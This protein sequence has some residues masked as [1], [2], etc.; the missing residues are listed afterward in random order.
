M[1]PKNI[2]TAVLLIFV[3]ASFGYLV[4]TETTSSERANDGQSPSAVTI[5]VGD[6]SL[7]TSSLADQSRDAPSHWIITYYFHNTQRCKTCL[8]IERLAEEALREEF[9]VEFKS[10]AIEWR[11]LNMEESPNTH[12]VDDYQ[13][14]TSSLVLVEIRNGEPS[15]WARLDRVWDLIHDDEIAFKQYVIEQARLLLEAGA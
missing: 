4:F 2:A 15:A 8:T 11:T 14:V 10:G 1:N 13:L 3:A 5:D 9:T 12:F 7:G 6:E